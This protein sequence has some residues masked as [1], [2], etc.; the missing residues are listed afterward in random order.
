[1]TVTIPAGSTSGQIGDLLADKDVVGS[2]FFF[3]L[4]A[5][6]AGADLRSGAFQMKRSMSYG[7]AIDQLTHQPGAAPVTRVVIPEGRSRTEIAAIA[8]TAD[9]SGD[10]AKSSRSSSKL[11]PRRYGAPR[12]AT[13]EGF[14]WPAT[15][16]LEPGSSV[17]TLVGKQLEAFKQNFDGL[18]MASAKR[19]NLTRYDVLTVASMI[20]REATIASERPKIAAVIYNRLRNGTPLGIDATIRFSLNNWTQPLKQSELQRDTPYNTRTRTGLPPGPIG[21]PGLA[22]IKAALRPAKVSYLFYVVKP[23]GEGAH[24][25][26][27]TDAQFQKDV[28]AY[29]KARNDRGGKD[30]S[31]C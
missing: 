23:C 29:N 30:P 3:S 8:R 16:E 14:L 9:L 31:H 26:S 1:V 11:K 7:A 18:S 6:L 22:S 20:E 28:A 4:R 13:L 19:R 12:K 15:Y 2:S 21:N 17:A 5:R 27:S 10:Y 25:F 24:A